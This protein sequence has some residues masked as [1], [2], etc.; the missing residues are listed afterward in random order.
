MNFLDLLFDR[1]STTPDKKLFNP[2]LY[3][4]LVNDCYLISK[5][6]HTSYADVLNLTVIEKNYL[7]DFIKEDND[8]E[9]KRIQESLK[10][11][12]K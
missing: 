10:A 9:N 2:Q 5:F 12:K 8:R 1:E 6:L 4:K 7:L 11:R 3:R